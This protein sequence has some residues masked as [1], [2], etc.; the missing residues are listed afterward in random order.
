MPENTKQKFPL[1]FSVDF[2]DFHPHKKQRNR[3]PPNWGPIFHP[4][5]SGIKPSGVGKMEKANTIANK[6]GGMGGVRLLVGLFL[7]SWQGLARGCA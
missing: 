1:Q 7:D 6:H 5:V 4:P 3:W 2:L